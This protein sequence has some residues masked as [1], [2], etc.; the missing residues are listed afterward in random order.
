[1][2]LAAAVVLPV[3][4][5]AVWFRPT[6]GAS[7]DDVRLGITLLK[8]SAAALAFSGLILARTDDP[9]GSRR[10][11]G[12]SWLP[13][14]AVG[15]LALALRS[16]RLDA[17]LWLDEIEMLVRY[18][19]LDL[20]QI[21]S[22]YD[23][24]NHHPL[25]TVLARLS[26][27][28]GG[29]ED[30]TIRVPAVLFGVAGIAAMHRFALRLVG[31]TEALLAAVVLA[32]S[33]HHVWF[34]QNARGYTAILL[35]TVLGTG[36]F[37]K[38]VST[39]RPPR[40]LVWMYAVVMSLAA[41]THLTAAFI[42]F[43]HALALLFVTRWTTPAG[44]SRAV[45]P[46]V[47]LLLS[48]LLTVVLYSPMLPQVVREITTPT[49]GVEVEWTSPRW[50]ITEG[51]RALTGGVPGGIPVLLLVLVVLAIGV[52]SLWRESR[53]AALAMFLPVLVT[54]AAVIAAGHNLWP[55]FFFFAAGFI[56][57]AAIRG[58][59]AVVH[60]VVSRRP[61]HLAVA[62]ASAVAVLSLLTVPRAWQPKQQ[63]RAALEFVNAER[64]PNDAVVALDVVKNV[65]LMRAWAP[66]WYLADGVPFIGELER[67]A[68]RTWVVYTLPT[69]IRAVAPALW[70]HVS[71]PRY[72]PVRIFPA[73]VGGGEIH[74]V[75]H[76]PASQ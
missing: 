74:V 35:F 53:V 66:D 23:T 12:G 3:D 1:V 76:E 13:V 55:R 50:M 63:F 34:S 68:E 30:W 11:S 10:S 58:G 67:R 43:G 6:Y 31:A 62:G 16:Y 25:Y 60:R 54:A 44:R 29:Q 47:A 42:A 41:Y 32:V 40:R 9:G 64:G 18:V 17:E 61:Q 14:L 24:Q 65:Y 48:A 22:T 21:V 5:T 73:T 70:E 33:Y 71:P 37:L 56:V 75:R 38:L 46:V 20:R 26:W 15:A 27:L 19:P 7:P 2:L 52:H 39:E 69:R 8:L 4:A 49:M 36:A 51:A 59:F 57:L 45:W 72:Q 28:A